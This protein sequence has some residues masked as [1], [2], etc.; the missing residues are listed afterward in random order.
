LTAVELTVRPPDPNDCNRDMLAAT[1]R[2]AV[3]PLA[4]VRLGHVF[5]SRPL[6]LAILAA[7]LLA[8]AAA[9]FGK[10]MPD[11]LAVWFRRT[12]LMS[13][14]LWPRRTILA[15]EGFPDGVARVARGADFTL[16]V[17]ADMTAQHVPRSVRIEYRPEGAARHDAT[18]TREGQ[19]VA[20][21]DHF[22]AY[23]YVFRGIL[24]PIDLELRGGDASIR[25]L[26]IEVVDAP[27]LVRLDAE[28]RYPDY[29]GRTPRT[30][31]AAGVVP[32]P[33]GTEVTL[34]AEANKRL[35][36]VQIVDGEVAQFVADS[37]TRRLH[38]IIALQRGAVRAGHGG[39]MAGDSAERLKI[40]A[41][42]LEQLHE[43][44]NLRLAENVPS[45]S[46][47]EVLDNIDAVRNDI[48]QTVEGQASAATALLVEDRLRELL[49]VVGR[50]VSFTR[51]NFRLQPI[52]ETKTL[53]LVLHD[54]DGIKSNQPIRIVLSA[55]E[56]QPPQPVIQ[57]RGIGSAITP[58]AR[59][60]FLGG[61][62]D[63]HGIARIWLEYSVEG[64]EPRRQTLKQ[65]E[66]I[67]T[68]VW[69]DEAFEVDALR[70]EPGNKIL[71]AVKASDRYNLGPEPNIGT[72]DRWMLDVVTPE[73]LRA[74]LE[75]R[76]IVLRQR[77]E[78]IVEDVEGIRDTLAGLTF[79]EES[80]EG[81]SE[82]SEAAEPGDSERL[83]TAER[84]RAVRLL[85]IQRSR[86]NGQKDS[87]ETAGVAEAFADI[88]QELV[89][90]RI[91]TEELRI[92]IEQDIVAPLNRLV[93]EDYVQLDERLARLETT[94][95]DPEQSPG[96]RDA[97]LRQTDM[98]LKTMQEV[99][100]R[101]LELEDFNEAVQL[102]RSIIEE[103]EQ[104]REAVRERRKEKLRQLLED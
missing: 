31:P 77:F 50:L 29:M 90:N 42:Q 15:V 47:R 38:E 55:V 86:Q 30:V 67:A 82:G 73:K 20:G 17:N 98:I 32:I 53:E 57:L 63:D 1:C 84:R 72:G 5:D 48:L 99:L 83:D 75:S 69:I 85:R 37:M 68:Q 81:A 58:Q 36:H 51:F 41:V 14:E 40:A 94:H 18:M 6:R 45:G 4:R 2:T 13:G 7:V 3:E 23:S 89:N 8:G 16:I 92:R 96:Q 79:E 21:R 80:S 10:F 12:V 101:M 103:Q 52:G 78:T 102:L 97:A 27:T 56:D 35:T 33:L 28:C 64:R 19:A 60:P 43:E 49:G 66:A 11:S 61:V 62:H 44:A 95:D 25:G 39:E 70:L 93:G 54:V 88:R 100:S 26:R 71:V 76:E 91:Y 74:M 24:A 59:L 9:A 104:L 22:Q 87:H 46:L 65:L 34:R